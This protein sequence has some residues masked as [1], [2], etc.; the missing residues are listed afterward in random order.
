M[1]KLLPFLI[2]LLLGFILQSL[3][4]WWII[5]WICALCFFIFKQ[6]PA[7]SMLISFFAVFLLWAVMSFLQDYANQGIL[8]NQIG[9]LLGGVSGKMLILISAFIGALVGALGGLTG[10]LGR[11][12]IR[13]T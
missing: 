4:P 7:Q 1:K 6:S 8:S 10:A 2:I 11:K 12:I 3:L 5:W 13:G 9:G